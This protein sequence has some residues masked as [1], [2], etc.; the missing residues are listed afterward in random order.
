[1]EDFEFRELI[2]DDFEQIKALHDEFFPVKYSDTF[3]RNATKGVGI[4]GGKLYNIVVMDGAGDNG[5]DVK[6]AERSPGYEGNEESNDEGNANKQ[7]QARMVGFLLAQVFPA[8]TVESTSLFLP[9]VV[10][11]KRVCYILTL[12]CIPDYRRIGL[13]SLLI[14][15]LCQ[16][17]AQDK[18]CGAVYLHV[19]TTNKAA[20]GFYANNDFLCIKHLPGFYTIENADYDALIYAHY[21]NGYHPPASYMMDRMVHATNDVMGKLWASFSLLTCNSRTE[22]T[23][24]DASYDSGKEKTQEVDASV[25]VDDATSRLVD[26][27][28]VLVSIDV[29][30]STQAGVG[31]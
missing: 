18:Q 25:V 19:I 23:V 10:A 30:A 17:M 11:P 14:Y 13:A 21:L 28:G 8:D 5:P 12:G 31:V 16:D 22:A 27:C 7:R 6:A 4:R 2:E 24:E 9:A 29:S 15:K 26:K 20:L 3:Y 1:M